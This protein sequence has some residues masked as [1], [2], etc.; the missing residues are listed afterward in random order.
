M[1]FLVVIAGLLF[2][3]FGGS[4]TA[5]QQDN[6]YLSQ[7]AYL[8]KWLASTNIT[9]ALIAPVLLPVLLVSMLSRELHGGLWGFLLA[10]VV[11]LYSLGRGDLQ[12]QVNEYMADLER[13]DL[14]AAFHDE[15]VFNQGREESQASNWQELH[16]QAVA[17]IAYRYFEH[18]FAVVFWFMVAGVAGALLYRLTLLRIDLGMDED[19]ESQKLVKRWL[20]LLEW[21]PVRLFGLS[22]AFVGDFANGIKPWANTLFSFSDSSRKVL[23]EYTAGALG[24]GEENTKKVA[25]V[26][27]IRSLFYRGLVCAVSVIAL[28]VIFV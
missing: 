4:V 23:G 13:E 17:S 25:E 2:L 9:L 3:R 26:A 20:W 6:W 12:Q 1:A 18:F 7:D 22:M 21:L 14:Q 24:L 11:F 28:W 5:I 19:I 10:L 27:A 16:D 15:A 8:K